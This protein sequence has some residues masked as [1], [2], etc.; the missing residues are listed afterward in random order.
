MLKVTP[1]VASMD[2]DIIYLYIYTPVYIPV[3]VVGAV[4]RA[5]LYRGY[6]IPW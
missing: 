4:S 5:G 1:E 3:Y 6:K 2:T